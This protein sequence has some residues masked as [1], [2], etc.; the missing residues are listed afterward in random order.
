MQRKTGSIKH[1][2]IPEEKIS[3]KERRELDALFKEMLA[4][5]EIPWREV[6]KKKPR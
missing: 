6:F 2:V 5:K 4:G 3:K 1:N